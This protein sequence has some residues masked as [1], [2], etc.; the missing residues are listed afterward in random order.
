MEVNQLLPASIDWFCGVYLL[1]SQRP[2]HGQLNVAV[3]QPWVSSHT[4]YY[5]IS[6]PRLW[7]PNSKL[8]RVRSTRVQHI[9]N[10]IKPNDSI[11][12]GPSYGPNNVPSYARPYQ[13][14]QDVPSYGTNNISY[15][16]DAP[17][18]GTNC[19]PSYGPND[20]YA[21]PTISVNTVL[22]P[23]NGVYHNTTTNRR[24]DQLSKEVPWLFQKDVPC[25]LEK[26]PE[27]IG[28]SI[29]AISS[30]SWWALLCLSVPSKY[31]QSAI[32]LW[33]TDKNTHTMIFL[34]FQQRHTII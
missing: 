13:T 16:N 33:C 31:S 26:L 20:M 14:L 32:M 1:N 6:H 10:L 22:N 3:K 29:A 17:S 24:E 11:S 19:V 21:P 18:Y 34:Q 25:A 7:T 9:I 12:D 8:L 2:S 15:P 27:K 23:K 28:W 4:Q 30:R 5:C